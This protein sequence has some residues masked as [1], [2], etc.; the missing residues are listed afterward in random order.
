M[1]LAVNGR[2]FDAILKASKGSLRNVYPLAIAAITSKVLAHRT[3]ERTFEKLD[4]VFDQGILSRQKDFDHAFEDM[5][6]SLPKRV[7]SLIGKR[8]HMEDDL[9]FLP[10]QASDLLA[11]YLR[12]KLSVEARGE[13]FDCAIWKALCKVGVNLDAFLT[14]N[15]LIDL[16]RRIEEKLR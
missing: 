13:K 12:F 7:T 11:S 5:M 4:F 3:H 14:T 16:R 10:L 6:I 2:A 15:A 8:P 1:T 9:E